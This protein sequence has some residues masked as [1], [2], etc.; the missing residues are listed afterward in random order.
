MF[1]MFFQN[2]LTFPIVLMTLS[3]NS[4]FG[5]DGIPLLMPLS[6]DNIGKKSSGPDGSNQRIP[7]LAAD[8]KRKIR[9][10]PFL[11]KMK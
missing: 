5:G 3:P 2:F 6:K 10:K 9:R 1:M 4:G 11:F 7:P 8:K